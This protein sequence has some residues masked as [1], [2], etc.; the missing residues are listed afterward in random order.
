MAAWEFQRM[1]NIAERRGWHRFISMQNYL[2]LIYRE[3]EREMLPYCKATGVGVIPWSPVARGV[4]ARPWGSGATKREQ[5]DAYLSTL[6]TRDHQAD[7]AVVDRVEEIAK[8]RGVPMA[9]VATAWVL[10][11]G[12]NPVL[13]LG[14]KE[15][16]DQAIEA[17][18]LKLS[19]EEVKYLE[20]PYVPKKVTGY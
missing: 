20:E 10:G 4:L 11:K 16:I 12:A 14:S 2:N 13:G 18:K 5:T 7:K 1:Q 19:E 6:I 8:K 3:E 17:T 9:A 15:R